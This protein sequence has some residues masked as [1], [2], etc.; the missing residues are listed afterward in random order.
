M[1]HFKLGKVFEKSKQYKDA[2]A[3]YQEAIKLDPDNLEAH[4]ELAILYGKRG[5]PLKLPAALLSLKHLL[6]Q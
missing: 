3:E 6:H 1:L 5:N 4:K 2:I